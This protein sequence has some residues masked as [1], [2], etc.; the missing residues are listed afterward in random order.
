M[1]RTIKQQ[2]IRSPATVPKYNDYIKRAITSQETI[3]VSKIQFV[4]IQM[5]HCPSDPPRGNIY[6]VRSGKQSV[7]YMQL[8]QDEIGNGPGAPGPPGGRHKPSAA[9]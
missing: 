1:A 5:F 3:T 8:L 9:I 7:H 6:L 4:L 2:L